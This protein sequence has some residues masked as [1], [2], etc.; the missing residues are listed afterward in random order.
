MRSEQDSVLAVMEKPL[1]DCFVNA[2]K[3][4]ILYVTWWKNGG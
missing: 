2:T 4:E 3:F 1:V